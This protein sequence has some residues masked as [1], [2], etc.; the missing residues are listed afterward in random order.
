MNVGRA[1]FKQFTR[2]NNGIGKF[3]EV[4]EYNVIYFDFETLVENN[5]HI[6]YCVSYC[7]GRKTESNAIQF[8]KTKAFM[9]L[10]AN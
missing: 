9:E 8:S 1:P 10:D 4:N 3:A 5:E 6:P 2:D 7:I